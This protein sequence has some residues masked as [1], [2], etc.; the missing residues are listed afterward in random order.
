MLRATKRKKFAVPQRTVRSKKWTFKM[1][2]IASWIA[3]RQL[4]F[5]EK[6]P[7]FF[8][9]KKKKKGIAKKIQTHLSTTPNF[10]A[11]PSALLLLLRLRVGTRKCIARSAL[12]AQVR[13][14]FRNTHSKTTNPAS[15]ITK[16]KISQ[17]LK[18]S[19]PPLPQ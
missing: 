5:G 13:D 2:T 11:Q 8:T 14:H 17:Q 16:I 6:L 19:R 9:F 3:H 15:L 18:R 1:H 7:S 4:K 10:P 12:A